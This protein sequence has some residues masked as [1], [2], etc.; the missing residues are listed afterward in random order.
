ML[1]RKAYYLSRM[2][3]LE[4]KNTMVSSGYH[5]SNVALQGFANC[6]QRLTKLRDDKVIGSTDFR[7]RYWAIMRRFVRK[8]GWHPL[9]NVMNEA[10]L[11]KA[12]QTVNKYGWRRLLGKP[13]RKRRI[14]GAGNSL[15]AGAVFRAMK[16]RRGKTS[17]CIWW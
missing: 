3:V 4:R 17:D 14:R 11:S 15:M 2:L 16:A 1:A 8:N 7:H 13:P 12:W 5:G 9:V 10:D 6:L